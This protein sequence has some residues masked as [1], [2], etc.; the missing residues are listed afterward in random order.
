MEFLDP[1]KQRAYMIRLF[2]GYFL[3]AIALALTAI[4]L[5]YQANGFGITK[6]GK[7]VQNGLVFVSSNPN[8]ADVYVDDQ[9]YKD[10][11]NTRILLQAG[12]YN[13]R[14]QR[15]GYRSWHR[16]ISIEEGIVAR[17]DYPLLI[18]ETLS[19][20]TVKSYASRPLLV[21]DSPDRRFI[22][23]QNGADFTSFDIYDTSSITK[24][25][26]AYKLPTT[27]I[28]LTNGTHSWK[29]VEWAN[30]NKHVL[31][32]H[33]AT[34]PKDNVVTTEYIML[35]R[36][37]ANA[38]INL[39]AKLNGTG[40]TVSLLDKKYDKYYLYDASTKKLNRATF[41][42]PQPQLVL[43]N[44]LQFKS[45]GDDK[46]LYATTQGATDGKVLVSL[47]DGK[48]T[49]N[50]RQ[51]TASSKYLLD[52]ASYD[53]D[54]YVLAGTS[55]EDRSYLY[56]NPQASLRDKQDL[57][58]V[59]ISI[60]KV[61]EAS[62]VSFSANT[63]FVMVQGAQSVAVYDAENDKGYA[64]LLQQPLDAPQT[65]AEWMDGHR[66]LYTS[67]GKSVICDFDNTNYQTLVANDIN[68]GISFDRD[69]SRLYDVRDSGSKDE[70]GASIYNLELTWL[71][72]KADQ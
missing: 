61:K 71:R 7:V 58:L 70:A 64:Y 50:L 23:I 10:R 63:R 12:K 29:L 8:P 2:V 35:D 4:I 13:F 54:W 45:Y 43:E 14:L 37:N 32:Q 17:Y 31:L 65:H 28:G 33:V 16:A 68:Y 51:V 5:L 56:K 9:R 59:P 49:Y 42:A 18:P 26:I 6:N 22:I 44:V 36:E 53:G 52:M 60:L 38:S 55:S 40:A 62:Y 15:D 27:I 69:Y 39:T 34:N 25:P 1:R 66:L 24:A 46:L 3:V 67:S 20:N 47:L 57:P 19:T 21:T 11:T 30:D 48:N 72:T 41:D